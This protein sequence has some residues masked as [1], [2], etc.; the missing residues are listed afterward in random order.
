MVEQTMAMYE[1]GTQQDNMVEQ[2]MQDTMVEQYDDNYGGEYDGQFVDQ[3]YD[4][5]MVGQG[6]Q[7]GTGTGN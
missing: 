3:G 1:D 4:T 2:Q 7:D 6:G 5:I